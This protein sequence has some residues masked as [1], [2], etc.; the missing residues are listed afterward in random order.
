M[1]HIIYEYRGYTCKI[2]TTAK[3][4]WYVIAHLKYTGT[5]YINHRV[6]INLKYVEHTTKFEKLYKKHKSH[7]VLSELI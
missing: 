1:T 6:N 5:A 3:K 7:N 2:V 4:I